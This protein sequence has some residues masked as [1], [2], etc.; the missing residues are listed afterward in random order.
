MTVVAA[1]KQQHRN[2][3]DY[4]LKPVTQ[5]TEVGSSHPRSLG[6]AAL[7]GQSP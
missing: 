1:L 3:L 7:I 2:A 4:P 5:L 6:D